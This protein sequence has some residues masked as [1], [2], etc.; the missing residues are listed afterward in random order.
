L[1][2][3]FDA[4][5]AVG[6]LEHVGHKNYEEFFRGAHA[7]LKEGGRMLTHTLYTPHSSVASNPWVDK[8]IFPNG[9]IAPRFMIE[10]EIS[11]YFEPAKDSRYPTFE[12][13]S[14]HY[15]PTLHAWKDRLTKS[16][17]EGRVEITEQEFRKFMF[18]FMLYAGAIRAGHVKVGQFLYE[19]KQ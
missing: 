11:N 5:S 19:K 7:N 18:Y 16:H 6:I 10:E 17:E 15:P 4:I 1:R 14:T 9:E 12:D 3:S 8:H 13:I 2:G